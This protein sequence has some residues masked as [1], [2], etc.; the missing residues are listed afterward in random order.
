MSQPSATIPRHRPA[1]WA[2]VLAFTLIYLSWGTTYYVIREGVHDQQLPPALFAGSRI[3]LAGL[4]LLVYLGLRGEPL[5]LKRL[6]LVW[7]GASGFLLFVLGNGLITA[8]LSLD[9]VP[10]NV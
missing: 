8:A 4:V 7:V 6:E 2:I 10:S 5:G 9:D 1:A 3:C